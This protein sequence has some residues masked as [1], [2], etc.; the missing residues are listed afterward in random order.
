MTREEVTSKQG[1]PTMMFLEVTIEHHS[2]ISVSHSGMSATM[3]KFEVVE[4]IAE[5]LKAMF[6]LSSIVVTVTHRVYLLFGRLRQ[7]CTV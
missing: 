5:S 7:V 2:I 1:D 6:L 3:I 4:T